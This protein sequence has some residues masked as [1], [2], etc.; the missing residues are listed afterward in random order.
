MGV[1]P[2]ESLIAEVENVLRN[3][4]LLQLTSIGFTGSCG[5]SL[6]KDNAVAEMW[7]VYMLRHS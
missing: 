2:D 7:N 3:E 4:P 6:L 1:D 5:C